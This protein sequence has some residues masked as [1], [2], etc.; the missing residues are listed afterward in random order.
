MRVPPIPPSHGLGA[1]PPPTADEQNL[2]TTLFIL[3]EEMSVLLQNPS[4]DPTQNAT[5]AQTLCQSL[6]YAY[7]LAETGKLPDVSTTELQGLEKAFTELSAMFASSSSPSS[8]TVTDAAQQVQNVLTT[9]AAKGLHPQPFQLPANI[10]EAGD[11]MAAQWFMN[12]L[13]SWNP[14][15]DQKT[16]QRLETQLQDM[17]TSLDATPGGAKD[18]INF[19]ASSVEIFGQHLP[20]VS[21]YTDQIT[22]MIQALLGIPSNP[23]NS[24][25][26]AAEEAVTG[27]L[28]AI[29]NILGQAGLLPTALGSNSTPLTQAEITKL[30]T[31]LSELDNY[32]A[33]NS[34]SLPA[35]VV[36]EI[37]TLVGNFNYMVSQNTPPTA[38][39]LQAIAS[40][41]A[42]A[43]SKLGSPTGASYTLPSDNSQWDT[44][45]LLIACC[46]IA[47]VCSSAWG[48][49]PNAPQK[50]AIQD[51]LNAAIANL[52]A[53]DD[54][55]AAFELSNISTM[56]GNGTI[57]AK[58]IANAILTNSQLQQFFPVIAPS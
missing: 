40:Q 35:A 32:T 36:T 14:T 57:G 58:D 9:L 21:D 16:L 26:N 29:Y 12:A 37:H 38:S 24:T 48:H 42:D 5:S 47:N 10:D 39:S 46:W 55:S 11:L 45:G 18:C 2:Y 8:G 41:I 50:S 30:C 4:A 54:T 25:P 51:T 13:Y 19:L 33:A 6:A 20:G 43:L 17:A 22:P 53:N 34:S 56:Y 27:Y 44:P 31:Y 23:S 15:S 49:N 1:S 7:Q 52:N 3:Q 28:T